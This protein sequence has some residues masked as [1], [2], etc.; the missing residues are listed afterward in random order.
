MLDNFAIAASSIC[1]LLGVVLLS[2][3]VSKLDT[4]EI[5]A[6]LGGAALLSLGLT[7][8][9]FALKNKWAWRQN[10]KKYREE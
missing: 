6:V 4:N 10:Y 9:C 1:L 8:I 2:V 3:G 7:T 5:L